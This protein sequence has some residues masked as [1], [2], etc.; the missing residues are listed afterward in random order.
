MAGLAATARFPPYSPQ[1]CLL[2]WAF[3]ADSSE[4][5]QSALLQQ[6][7]PGTGI[8]QNAGEPR[9]SF[10]LLRLLLA[11][12]VI[13][14]HAAELSDGNRSR[15]IFHV[16]GGQ[17]SAGDF[18]VEAFFVVSGC[19]IL[20]SWSREPRFGAYLMKRILRI[21]PAFLA[22][23]LISVFLVG[24]LGGGPTY[25]AQLLRPS[26]LLQ[27][28][29]GLVLLTYPHTPPV[30]AGFPYP[31]VNGALWTITYEFRCY[32]L[33]PVLAALGLYSRR[34][35]FAIGWLAVVL[36][37]GLYSAAHLGETTSLGLLHF[38]PFFLAGN[39]A[40]LYRDRM[41]WGRTLG[42]V[43]M[44]A[45]ILSM[46]SLAA[47]M[48]VLPIAGSYAILWLALSEWSPLRHFSPSSDISYGVY[49]YGWPTQKLL[50]WYFPWLPLGLQ[51]LATLGVSMLLG[52]ASWRLIEKRCLALKARFTQR[53]GRAQV[54]T[55]AGSA[56]TP[57]L[58]LLGVQPKAP[59]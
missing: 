48:F 5:V 20:E 58:G 12:M 13:V 56:G 11:S 50:L 7:K 32:L 15:E 37:A 39:C 53:D 8:R 36:G 18:A 21:V 28:V 14:A 22:A 46:G 10:T 25:F 35:L 59:L 16:L 52:W 55:P 2:P 26:G 49:L 40:Y 23:Y 47:T 4:R 34:L 38:A 27:L 42:G 44:A 6:V 17:I 3:F 24:W 30:F 29:P 33:I 31:T 57:L 51:M 19:L 41:R 9:N 54:L 1:V 43:S 45:A